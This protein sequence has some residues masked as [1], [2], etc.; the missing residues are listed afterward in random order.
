MIHYTDLN[1]HDATLSTAELEAVEI[2]GRSDWRSYAVERVEYPPGCIEGMSLA[3]RRP[4]ATEPTAPAPPVEPEE[5]QPRP[6]TENDVEYLLARWHDRHGR[7]KTAQVLNRSAHA[8]RV[9][10]FELIFGS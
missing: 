9:K 4:W 3:M 8:C 6:W 1:G 7:K 10:Y 2:T 5:H